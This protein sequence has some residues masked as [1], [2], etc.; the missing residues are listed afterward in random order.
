MKRLRKLKQSFYLCLVIT[1]LI[2]GSGYAQESEIAK[3]PS[4]PITFIVPLPAGSGGDLTSRLISREAEKFLGQPIT[5]VNKP[6]GSYTIGAAAIAASK[7]DGYTIGY[8]TPASLFITPFLEKLPYHPLRDFQRIIQ[9]GE[10]TFGVVV[11]N[12]S[13]FKSFEDLIAFARHNPKKLTYGT[14]GVN[15]FSNLAMERIAKLKGVQFT[16]IPFRGGA[17]FQQ[18]LM[19]GHLHF[20]AGDFNTALL[21]AGETRLLLLLT[22]S[23]RAEYPHIPILKDIGYDIPYPAISMISGP[24]GLPEAI[25][26]KLEEAFTKAMKE[27]AFIKGMKELHLTISYRSSKELE[28]YMIRT[29]Q[30]VSLNLLKPGASPK[31]LWDANNTFLEKKGYFPER[32]AYAHGQGYHFVERPIIRN[33]EP[34]KI[35]SGM[36]I[37]VHPT[38]TNKTVWAGVTDNYIVTEIGAGPCIHKTPKE[39]IV[40]S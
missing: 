23:P 17:E 36:N 5:V 38:A 3:Y 9:Y 11:R 4:R 22:E 12:D 15:S 6:G 32:R 26:K 33:D 7:P 30:K 37:T 18:A 35:K 14:G 31:D 2:A 34:M 27:P 19:G 20:S 21:E 39:I 25:I 1:L 28:D 24:K 29:A 8:T 10:M 16:H 40:I 13:P